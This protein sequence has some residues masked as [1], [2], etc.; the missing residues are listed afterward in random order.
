MIIFF[1][2]YVESSTICIMINATLFQSSILNIAAN[3]FT[4]QKT[5]VIDKLELYRSFIEYQREL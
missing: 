3:F 2:I 4:F 5:F 1:E